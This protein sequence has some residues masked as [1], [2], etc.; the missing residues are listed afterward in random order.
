MK[1]FVSFA[2]AAVYVALPGTGAVGL[3]SHE[4][5]IE[6]P[7]Q[8][9]PNHLAELQEVD[10]DI[11]I[12]DRLAQVDNIDVDINI[13]DAGSDGD[14]DDDYDEEDEDDDMM[15]A[16]VSQLIPPE[17]FTEDEDE[18]SHDGN[19]HES[20]SAG[21]RAQDHDLAQEHDLAQAGSS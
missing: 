10:V 13:G 4:P 5:T 3:G 14:E 12:G 21:Q 17:E 1:T 9:L 11:N 18:G 19:H 15:L 8:E 6:L 16:Q 7:E 20:E 2:I